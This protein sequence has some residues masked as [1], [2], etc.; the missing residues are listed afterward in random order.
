M[1]TTPQTIQEID[2]FINKVTAKYTAAADDI[3]TDIHIQVKPD[4]GELLAF[5]DEMEE[6]TRVVITEWLTPTEEDLDE[7]ASQLLKK[8]LVEKRDEIERMHILHPFSFV[9]I[10][11]E[12][13]TLHDLYLVDDETMIVDTELLKGLDEELDAFLRDLMK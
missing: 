12:G 2:R 6:L 4:S 1:T 7:V 13:E 8:V 9:L 10:N 11:D 5:N 3:L